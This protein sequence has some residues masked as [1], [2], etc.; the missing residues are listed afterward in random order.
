M[1]KNR[2]TELSGWNRD[3][4][5][6]ISSAIV[7]TSLPDVQNSG[8]YQIV[9]LEVSIPL[10][11]L[12]QLSLKSWSNLNR[13]DIVFVCRVECNDDSSYSLP[14]LRTCFFESKK[15]SNN[16]MIMTLLVD[17]ENF[18]EDSRVKIFSNL[19]L[20][21]KR[22]S[23]ESNDLKVLQSLSNY[24]DQTIPESIHD[25]ILGIA[26]PDDIS[27]FDS[28]TTKN[29]SKDVVNVL[30]EKQNFAVNNCINSRLSLCEGPFSSGCT[31]VLKQSVIALSSSVN[32]IL[33]RSGPAVDQLYDDF[34]EMG[35]QEHC[36]VR[37]GFSSTVDNIQEKYKKIIKLNIDAINTLILSGLDASNIYTCGEAEYVLR[38]IVQ[39]R[40]D[41]FKILLDST[42]D[43]DELLDVYPFAKCLNFSSPDS[44]QSASKEKFIDHFD[45]ISKYFKIS[46]ELAPLELLHDG[47]YLLVCFFP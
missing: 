29:V 36:I 41:A 35:V 23:A 33:S 1:N 22:S 21:I 32:I 13:Q 45:R 24:S 7:S 6:I 19:N 4:V 3:S 12:D 38:G 17:P 30:T 16:C 31:S 37:L 43:L 27:N 40:W 47:N 26:H 20:L 9:E 8:K 18:D 10:A 44:I 5:E 11:Q 14:V 39:P 28:M 42:D 2:I 25:A 15:I 34:I 46:K